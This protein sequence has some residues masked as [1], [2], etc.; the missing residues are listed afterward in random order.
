MNPH[1]SPH[2]L[3][4]PDHKQKEKL[5]FSTSKFISSLIASIIS[6]CRHIYCIICLFWHKQMTFA[7]SKKHSNMQLKER[8]P[9]DTSCNDSKKCN[10]KR[11]EWVC[12]LI[13]CDIAHTSALHA[14]EIAPCEHL[15]WHPHNPFSASQM[16]WK[17]CTV[18]T[19]L[20]GQYLTAV[21][22]PV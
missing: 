12:N 8:Q 21:T 20:Y 9:R 19:S 14:L 2:N 5:L 10:R 18:W 13:M 15:R 16:H 22:P 6:A 17:K 3:D 11:T 7:K 4:S 1:H